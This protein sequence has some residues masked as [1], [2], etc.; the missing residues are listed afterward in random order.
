MSRIDRLLTMLLMAAASACST[1]LPPVL[2]DGP[3]A[4]LAA[5][6]GEWRGSYQADTG[7]AARSGSILFRIAA[8][9]GSAAGDVLM[10]PPDLATGMPAGARGAADPWTSPPAPAVVLTIRF[11]QAAGGTVYGVLDP[12]RDPVCGC[13]LRTEFAGTLRGDVIEGSYTSVHVEDGRVSG[14]HW[15][16][17]RYEAGR[18]RPR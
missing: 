9:G 17:E 4:D 12:Y 16:V 8:E 15:R 11:V 1:N 3:R 5:L 6:A 2:L 13:E 18:A 10:L 7:T 14:G